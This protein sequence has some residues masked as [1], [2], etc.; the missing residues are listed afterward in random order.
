MGLQPQS[1]LY[2]KLLES[3]CLLHANHTATLLRALAMT[4]PQDPRQNGTVPSTLHRYNHE[5]TTQCNMLHLTLAKD[6]LINGWELH[7]PNSS[8]SLPGIHVSI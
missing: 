2:H 7:S 6:F 5:R 1:R 4:D 3:E 8:L